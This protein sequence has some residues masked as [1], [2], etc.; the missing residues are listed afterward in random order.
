MVSSNRFMKRFFYVTLQIMDDINK[1]K[2]DFLNH[3]LSEGDAM[4]CLDARHAEVD[5]PKTHKTNP[6]LNLVFNLSFRRP[7]EV[8]EYGIYSTLSFGGRPYKCVIPFDAVWAIYEPSTQKGQVWDESIPKD[9]DLASQLKQTPSKT[10]VEKPKIHS[11][12]AQPP[13]GDSPKPKRDRSHLR[14]IK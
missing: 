3:L 7:I 6:V 1:D 2:Y 11:G 10:P 12:G 9:I 8:E 14:I 5:V 4:V 13:A